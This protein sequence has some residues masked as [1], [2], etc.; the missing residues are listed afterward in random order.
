MTLIV[1]VED[2]PGDLSTQYF[3]EDGDIAHG[4]IG[5]DDEWDFFRL[6]VTAGQTYTVSLVGIGAHRLADPKIEIFDNHFDLWASD[7]DSLPNWNSTV[8]FL[9][10]KTGYYFVAVTGYDLYDEYAYGLSFDN[11]TISNFDIAMG[12]GVIDAFNSWSDRGLSAT[13]SYAFRRSV[14]IDFA[15]DAN[16]DAVDT[17]EVLSVGQG[18]AVHAALQMFS[19]VADLTFVHVAEEDGQSDDATMLFAS[20]AADDGAGAYAYFPGSTLPGD[21]EGDVWLNRNSFQ[22]IGDIPLGGYEYFALM[23]EIGHAMGLSHPGNYN[24]GPDQQISYESSAQFAQDSHQYTLMSYWD[25][26][27]TTGVETG[28][29]PEPGQNVDNYNFGYPTTLLMLDILAL[30]NKYGANFSTRSEDST[31]GFNSNVGSIYCFASEYADKAFCIWDGDGTDTLDLSGFSQ[32]QTISLL[33]GTFSSVGGLTSNLSVAVGAVIENANG[34]FGNDRITGNGASNE[35]VGG[36]GD[37]TLDGSDGDDTAIFIGNV[38]DY[39]I[40]GNANDQSIVVQCTSGTDGTDKLYNIEWLHFWGDVIVYSYSIAFETFLLE[41]DEDGNELVGTDGDDSIRG[42]DGNDTISGGA[43]DDTLDGGAGNDFLKGDEGLDTVS[44]EFAESAVTVTLSTTVAQ[45]TFGAGTDTLGTIENLVGSDFADALTGSSADNRMEGGAGNDTLIGGSGSDSILGGAGNDSLSGGLGDDDL[46]GG[47]GNELFAVT[48]GIDTILDLSGSDLLVISSSATA[49]ADVTDAWTATVGTTNAGVANLTTAGL[50]I[51]LG[52]VKAGKGYTVTNT[53]AATT[54]IGSAVSDTLVGGAGNDTLVGGAG[55]DSLTGGDGDDVFLVA[56]A[57]DVVPGETITGGNGSDEVRF[58]TVIASTLVL[59][60]GVAV[61][62]VV[63]GTGTAVTAVSTGTGAINL[64]ASAAANGM[65]ILGNAGTNALTGTAYDDTIDGGSGNDVIEGGAGNDT[66]SGSEGSDIY[67]LTALSDKTTAEI[68]DSGANGVDE[69]RFAAKSVGTLALLAGDTGLERVVIG[70]GSGASAVATATTA[71]SIDASMIDNALTMVG[72]AGANTLTGT[73]YNDTIEGGAGNDSLTGGAGNDTFTVGAGVDTV[74]DL[75]GTDVLTVASGAIANATVSADWTATSGTTN[76]GVT[77][78]TSAGLSVDLSAITTGTAGFKVTD[79]G[80]AVTFA[81][82]SLADTLQGGLGNDTLDGG[83][84]NDSLTGGAGAD[85]FTVSAGTDIIADLSVE[86]IFTVAANATVNATVSSAWTASSGI[87]N[88]GT[89]NLNSAGFA[90]NLSAATGGSAGFKLTNTAATATTL[91]GSNFADTLVGGAGAD[92]LVG[93]VGN[94]TLTGAAGN[95][96]FTIALG[97]DSIK[98]LS[99]GDIFTVSSGATLNGTVS[100][101]WTA[102]VGTTNGGTANL[103][104]N[105]FALNLAAVTGGSAGYGVTN[106]ATTATNLTGSAWADTLVGGTGADTLVGG[107]GND[108]LTGNAGNDTFKVASGTDTITDLGGGDVFTVA[109][110]S[111]ANAT[112]S[113]AWT[114]TTGTTN[115]GTAT[116]TTNGFAVNFA[117]VTGGSAGY[118]VTNTGAAT[119]LTGSK[120]ADTLTGGTGNDTLLGGAGA[121]SLVGGDGNDLF[122]VALATDLAFGETITGG[123]GTD[124][125]RFTSTAASTLMLST[126][127]TVEMVVIGTGTASAAVLTGTTAL[128]LNASAVLNGLS[129]KG[130]AGANSLTGTGYNDSFDGGLGNDTLAGGAGNDTLFGGGGNDNITGGAGA[131]V[132]VFNPTPNATSNLDTIT[133]FVSGTDHINLAKSVMAALGSVNL[134]LNVDAFWQGAGVVKGHDASDRIVYNTS[135]GALY[136]DADGSGSGAAVQLAQ[137][138]TTASHPLS[139][140]AADFFVF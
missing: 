106:T 135:T 73:G 84:G 66:L 7:D 33:D 12:A 79:T 77:N 43:G 107:L 97:T 17:G 136:Y 94:D 54:L 32:D 46:T 29:Q 68:R 121:D 104:S 25:E 30:Q 87:T 26:S 53:G 23:H 16:G 92:T 13:L 14:D 122:V 120:F 9:A 11:G 126:S 44:Y 1:E 37:D 83:A 15:Q 139:L 6:N 111:T 74:T 3:I 110:S 45:K 85:T 109:A 129:I 115:A 138:G 58:A 18:N 90:V 105:G 118:S 64:N 36:E 28:Y 78:L 95:D 49:N 27:N 102:T 47:A 72:N 99:G 82:S 71:L 52:A 123:G 10:E 96:T 61:D 116:L 69:L 20:Y 31:Y 86:D 19:E 76:R 2:V 103:T 137:L 63:I 59:T 88:A 60:A 38:E 65:S 56:S 117:A 113:A 81:G 8:T 130:N 21:V 89:A 127:V 131:D 41:G 125:L 128:N 50:A 51:N 91:T 100:A 119:T 67:V 93:G 22:S 140:T 133:D 48:S 35:L 132:F 124:E 62:R 70:T 101:A 98:D 75:G 108:S 42:L 24:A 57:S 112:V 39:I 134:A 80:G 34:G 4:A 5:P 40:R 55:N 114:A